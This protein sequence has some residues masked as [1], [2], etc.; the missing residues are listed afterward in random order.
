V[1][2][3]GFGFNYST[4]SPYPSPSLFMKAPAITTSQQCGYLHLIAHNRAIPR[5]LPNIRSRHVLFFF[6]VQVNY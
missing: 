1:S 2:L 4:P 6:Y 3:Q 5:A